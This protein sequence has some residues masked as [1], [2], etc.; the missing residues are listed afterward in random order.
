MKSPNSMGFSNN[1]LNLI[2][3]NAACRSSV[4]CKNV[5]LVKD[6]ILQTLVQLL[7]IHVFTHEVTEFCRVSQK[8]YIFLTQSLFNIASLFYIWY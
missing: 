3:R 1:I 4:L 5:Y 8:Y 7:N 2:N 6:Q